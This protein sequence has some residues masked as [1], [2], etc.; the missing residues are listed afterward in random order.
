M[1]PADSNK[2][3]YRAGLVFLLFTAFA[4][5]LF[6]GISTAAEKKND[7]P[8]SAEQKSS[9]EKLHVVT[10]VIDGDTIVLN[11]SVTVR[12]IGVDTPEIGEPFYNEAKS[13]NASLVSGKKVR[14]DVCEEEPFDKYGRTLAYVYL[15]NVCVNEELLKKGLA[16]ALSIPPCGIKKYKEYAK[17]EA[18]TRTQEAG[19]WAD[20][21]V[22]KADNANSVMGQK[23]SVRG[24]ILSV[25]RGKKAI[26]LNF[27]TDYKHDFT[28]VIFIKD[29][30]NFT[31]FGI[32]PLLTY[33][34][35]DVIV[36]G[37]VK[38]HNGPE[39]I[40]LYPSNIEVLN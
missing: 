30:P 12:Y 10:H 23:A 6:S 32:N 40:L 33:S 17:L 21:K 34:G 20:E 18:Q 4:L 16:R 36:R 2:L 25:H 1:F 15:D 26:F 14:I 38:E 31:A 22:I 35:K 27:G 29:L 9:Q 24:K 8:Q 7:V 28:A 3:G 39:I 37:K 13:F 11:N 5:I 19:L